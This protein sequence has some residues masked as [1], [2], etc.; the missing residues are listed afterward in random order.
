[1]HL[2]QTKVESRATGGPETIKCAAIKLC[3]GAVYTA[4][5]HGDALEKAR[6]KHKNESERRFRALFEDSEDGFLT[7]N[8]RFVSR[9]EAYRIAIETRQIAR[10][11]Y[12][13]ALKDLW[14]PNT[15]V[16]TELGAL[17]FDNART[18]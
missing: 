17:G 2:Q 1:M 18:W 6:R 5:F 14:G 13:Q 3:D 9:Q 16:G 11:S 10:N 12:V 8:K 4:P 15:K 7:S